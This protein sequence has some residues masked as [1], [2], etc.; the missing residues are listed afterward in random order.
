[1]YMNEI[2]DKKNQY[3]IKQKNL[4]FDWMNIQLNKNWVK[5]EQV[6]N[7]AIHKLVCVW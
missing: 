1:M 4:T 2:Q 7:I 3:R 6:L 5:D